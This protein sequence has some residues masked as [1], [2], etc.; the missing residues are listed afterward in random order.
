VTV[1]A[2]GAIP[3]TIA[4]G[5][6][7]T[8]TIAWSGAPT[9]FG[10]VTV[11]TA[12][13]TLTAD[14]GYVFSGVAANFFTVAGA[15]TV[16]NPAGSNIVTATFPATGLPP[17]SI[18][19]LSATGGTIGSGTGWALNGG[20]TLIWAKVSNNLALNFADITA[21]CT[22]LGAGWRMPTVWSSTPYNGLYHYL[23]RLDNGLI[24]GSTYNVLDT[25]AVYV[26][27][28]K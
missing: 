19:T 17:G 8:G 24:Y 11:Y 15:T 9:T 22:A 13:I 6:N 5:T 26:S 25:E 3:A 2:Y 18:Q 7:F 28:V 16:T 21:H 23:I 4:T 1:P 20:E 14:A 12:T 10:D 27:C